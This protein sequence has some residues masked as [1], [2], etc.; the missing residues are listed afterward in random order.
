MGNIEKTILRALASGE[1]LLSVHAARRMS[2]R[3]VTKADL[4]S[5]G[6]TARSCVYQI[7]HGTW[8]I[9]GEDLD[10]GI[11]TATCAVDDCVVIVTL[12]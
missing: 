9:E 10:G 8:R 3:A 4:R 11:L 12:F 5:C 6:R 7:R 2:E 1:F